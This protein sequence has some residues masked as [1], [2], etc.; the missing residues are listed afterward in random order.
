MLQLT[1]MEELLGHHE[2]T[3]MHDSTPSVI[4]KKI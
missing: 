4:E 3:P 2:K 1:Q